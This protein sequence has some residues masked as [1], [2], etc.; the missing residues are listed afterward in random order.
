VDRLASKTQEAIWLAAAVAIPLVLD[1]WGCSSFEVPKSA[2]V[3][4]LALLGIWTMVVEIISGHRTARRAW[5]SPLVWSA[6]AMGLVSILATIA[7]ISPSQSLWGSFER[8][9]G[10]L[11]QL[12]YL[13]LFLLVAR[14][15]R[16]SSQ[17]ERLF[18]ALAWGSAPVV[19]YGLA[20]AAGLDPLGWHTD[21]ASPVLSTIGRANF[22]GSYLVLVVPVTATQLSQ[23]RRRW[24][25]ALL[26]TGQSACLALTLA[27]A[28]WIGAVGGAVVWIAVEA[29]RTHRP[30][31]TCGAWG[32]AAAGVLLVLLL[33]WSA[34]PLAALAQLPGLDRLVTLSRLDAGSTAARLA[35][36]KTTLPLI[37]A[38]PWLG[39]G[40]ETMGFLFL[41]FYPPQLVYYQGR[42][43]TV[44]RA[45][46][47]WL[48]LGVSAGIPG[49]V[50]LIALLA[51]LG[52]A[53]WRGL[54]NAPDRQARSM[55]VA[56]LVAMAGHLVELQFSFAVTT[57]ATVFWL[58]L[59]TVGAVDRG[60]DEHAPLGAAQPKA[61][62]WLPGVPPLLAVLALIGWL[63]VRSLLADTACWL[64]RQDARTLPARRV[65]AERAV[66]LWAPQPT[67][68]VQL[69]WRCLETGD[70]ACVQSELAKVHALSPDDARLWA[71]EGDL[72]ALWG[73]RDPL[74]YVRAERAYRRA[75]DLAP[76]IAAYH[77]SLG[78]A[79][80]REGRLEEGTG[81]VER[82]VDL[83]A[84]DY[85]AYRH[86]A[87]LYRAL[88]EDQRAAWALDRAD[89][90]EQKTSQ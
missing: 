70:L 63:C 88:G 10:L 29:R 22:V 43:V 62:D 4:A 66:R 7:S 41:R 34:G 54:R 19:L 61:V 52:W 83:D 60:L 55:W 89:Y 21:A 68:H 12:A 36:W 3:Q 16:T 51:C 32:L 49:M 46:N 59:G 50:T 35:V 6:L 73:E 11:T 18:C 79:L 64:G 14:A 39:Y 69:A 84:T 76:T 9:Q 40:P 80:A 15:L 24:A 25:Y 87:E 38:R 71:V 75:L 67:Y 78:L 37:A 57:S 81:E 56:L 45:H 20:Q 77:T 8:Q 17:V 82:A 31:W 44:D 23:A 26:L 65:A 58:L 90:W 13:A 27:R 5:R 2:L 86:L 42:Q 28:A 30:A 48:D 47:L 72:Y 33:N 85:V 74:Q 1:P 53:L